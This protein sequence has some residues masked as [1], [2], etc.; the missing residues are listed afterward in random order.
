MDDRIKNWTYTAVPPGTLIDARAV[1][2]LAEVVGKKLLLAL[3]IDDLEETRFQLLFG[4]NIRAGSPTPSDVAKRLEE[5]CRTVERLWRQ[6]DLKSPYLPEDIPLALRRPLDTQAQKIVSPHGADEG[7]KIHQ[8]L[9][10]LPLFHQAAAEAAER[11]RN[12]VLETPHRHLGNQ[13]LPLLFSQLGRIYEQSFGGNAGFSTNSE[14]DQRGGPFVRFVCAFLA[15]CKRSLDKE[16]EPSDEDV[17]KALELATKPEKLAE[18][19]RV[20]YRKTT[21]GADQK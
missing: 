16:W 10:G 21:K 15:I 8:S 18:H 13:A 1:S 4:S 17:I 20:W 19:I 6:L 9:A 11:A 2:E 14:T 7:N 12:M 5:I 3:P